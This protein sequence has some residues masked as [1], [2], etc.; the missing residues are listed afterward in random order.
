MITAG[1]LCLGSMTATV[2]W[3]GFDGVVDGSLEPA[4]QGAPVNWADVVAFV[5]W[6]AFML[7]GMTTALSSD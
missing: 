7:E 5:T 6:S 1:G 2:M 4:M 3:V